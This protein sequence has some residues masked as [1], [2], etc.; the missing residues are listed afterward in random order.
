MRDFTRRAGDRFA[1]SLVKAAIGMTGGYQISHFARSDDWSIWLIAVAVT[2]FAMAMTAI[3]VA[4]EKA[5]G[6]KL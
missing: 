1:V 5:C 2:G 6:V 4:I 3:E